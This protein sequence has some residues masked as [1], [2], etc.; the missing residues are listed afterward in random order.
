MLQVPAE[1][2]YLAQCGGRA[3]RGPAPFSTAE[4][5]APGVTAH[6]ELDLEERLARFLRSGGGADW[7]GQERV[8]LAP[9]LRRFGLLGRGRLF[10]GLLGLALCGVGLLS[11]SPAQATV[12][13]APEWLADL[14]RAAT[15]ARDERRDILVE[16]SA[17][18][19]Y[20]RKS[21]IRVLN[22]VDRGGCEAERSGPPR[23]YDD[24]F[25]RTLVV[26]WEASDR[27]CGKRLDDPFAQFS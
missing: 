26:F 3:R 7:S 18:T 2:L 22:H 23:V 4:P 20:H 17:I 5:R 27:V 12:A 10:T 6:L 1:L 16:F 15:R 14:S 9:G 21:A 13:P 25:R 11:R 19:G 8:A 24:I